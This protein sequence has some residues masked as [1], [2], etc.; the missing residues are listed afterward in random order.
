MSKKK[1]RKSNADDARIVELY[2]QRDEEAI[3]LTSEKYGSFLFSSAFNI[4]Q[5]RLDCEE[6][7]NDTYLKVWNSIPP[8]R[9]RSFIAFIAEL[10]RNTALDM[11]RKRMSKKR[12]PTELTVSM[13][14]LAETLGEG[15]ADVHDEDL[16]IAVRAFVKS[17]AE[18][19]RFVFIGR[20]YFARPVSD[21]AKELGVSDSAVY[22]ELKNLRDKMRVYLE[23]EGVCL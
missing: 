23:K 16:G 2:W 13:E 5:D 19:E 22:K 18:R 17:L 9:P 21:I 8:A 10:V 15:L 11:Y 4:L 20:Y 14:E 1:Q 12:V 7:V 3:S 6:C